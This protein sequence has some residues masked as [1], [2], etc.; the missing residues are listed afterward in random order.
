MAALFDRADASRPG[1]SQDVPFTG[2]SAA[3][4]SFGVETYQ[5]RLSSTAACRFRVVEAAGGTAVATD[6]LIPPNWIEY[7]CV[8]PGQ[9]IAV[10]QNVGAGS[11][12]ITE[13]S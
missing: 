2:T 11:L 4:T 1:L 13:M 6:V 3:S 9:K 10:I 7:I 5:V 8:T 12:N